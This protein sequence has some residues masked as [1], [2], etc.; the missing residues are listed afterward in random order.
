MVQDVAPA[1]PAPSNEGG[2]ATQLTT[3]ELQDPNHP[4]LVTRGESLYNEVTDDN[5]EKYLLVSDKGRIKTIHLPQPK[6]DGISSSAIIDFLNCSFHFSDNEGLNDFFSDFIPV[7]G[8]AFTPIVNRNA[9]FHFYEHSFELGDSKAIFAYGGNNNTAMLSFTGFSCHMVPNWSRLVNFLSKIRHAK[10]TRVDCAHDDYDGIHS[11]DFALQLYLDGKFNT[12]GREPLIDQKVNW[13][14]PDGK[15]RTLYVGSA[16][17]GKLLRVY[18]KGM[19]LGAKWHPWVRWELQYGS[20]DREIPW[21]I[22][23]S[24]GK[25][26]AGGYPNATGWISEEQSRI[27]TIQNTTNIGYDSLTKFASLSYGKL[28]NLMLETEGSAEAVVNKLRR[29]GLPSRLVLPTVAQGVK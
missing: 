24:P 4:R 25:Y 16:E 23:L 22:I 29:D 21:E 1:T 12:G 20:R 28:I 11:V 6:I 17:N 15:G 3:D 18:E 8:E 19:Q 5:G 27:L 26:L 10:I 7:V 9:K 2:L 13:I 14:R